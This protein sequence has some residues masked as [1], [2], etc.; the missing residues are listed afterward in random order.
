MNAA[1]PPI[2]SRERRRSRAHI[3]RRMIGGGRSL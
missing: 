2:K 3:T 1:A